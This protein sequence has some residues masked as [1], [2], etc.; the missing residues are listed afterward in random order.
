MNHRR[1]A[2][3]TEGYIVLSADDVRPAMSQI[4]ARFIEKSVAGNMNKKSKRTQQTDVEL[5]VRKSSAR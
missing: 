1:K 2:D 5:P 4:E 3:V